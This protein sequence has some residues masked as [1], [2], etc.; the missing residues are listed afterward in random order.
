MNQAPETRHSLLLRL[1]DPADREAWSEF[2]D[3][4]EPVIYRLACRKGLQ[5]AD[6]EDLVQQVLMSVSRTIERWEPDR[7]RARFRTWLHTVA[8]NAIINALSRRP[9]AQAS[10]NSAVQEQLHEVAQCEADSQLLRLEM[11]R[12]IFRRAAGEVRREFHPA[13]WEAF[14]LTAVEQQDVDAVAERLGKERG[15]IYAARSRIM[16][17]LK[18]KVQECLIQWQ[19]EIS[20]P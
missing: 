4:Y 12:E 8:L 19:A 2:V 9:A 15:A 10:G 5:H 6:A 13:T 3:L 1:K 11:R 14:W 17:R 20:E 16:R 7:G 18:E